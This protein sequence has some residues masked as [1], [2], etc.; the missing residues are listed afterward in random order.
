MSTGLADR[1]RG[2]GQRKITPHACI[3]DS[4]KDIRTLLAETPEE[5]GFIASE[6]AAAVGLSVALDLR[7]PDLVVMGLST[8][9]VKAGEVLQVLSERRF[10]GKVLLIGPK[11]ALLLAAV[12]QLGEELGCADGGARQKLRFG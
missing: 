10:D 5:L 8:D 2:F 1:V 6:C 3:A 4:K 11:D 7:P 12:R 9:G